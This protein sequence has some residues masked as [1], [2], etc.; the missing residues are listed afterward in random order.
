M[1]GL[2]RRR[3]RTTQNYMSSID[4]CNICNNV[5]IVHKLHVLFQTQVTFSD[6]RSLLLE[7][8]TISYLIEYLLFKFQIYMDNSAFVAFISNEFKWL[9]FRG[10]HVTS[11]M[12]LHIPLLFVHRL[13]WPYMQDY[14]SNSFLVTGILSSIRNCTIL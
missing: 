1:D 2:Q 4:W 14:I 7:K 11:I 3:R 10:L 12:K 13:H 9:L 6:A 8:L 5:V